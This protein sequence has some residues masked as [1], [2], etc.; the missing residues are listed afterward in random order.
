[1]C[2]IGFKARFGVQIYGMHTGDPP[3]VR[4]ITHGRKTNMLV[5]TPTFTANFNTNSGA[6][7]AEHML[8]G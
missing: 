1:L 8:P 3:A 5:I 2:G 6:N 7:T 4:G